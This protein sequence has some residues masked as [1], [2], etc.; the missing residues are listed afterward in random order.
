MIRMLSIQPLLIASIHKLLEFN[1]RR[2]EARVLSP[3]YEVGGI[4][5]VDFEGT[6]ERTSSAFCA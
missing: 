3:I 6:Q 2:T 4:P 5:R 1:H